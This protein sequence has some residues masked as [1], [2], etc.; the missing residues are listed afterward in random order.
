[1]EGSDYF[2]VI[3]SVLAKKIDCFY[4]KSTGDACDSDYVHRVLVNKRTDYEILYT[5]TIGL[6]N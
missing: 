3:P 1:M 6:V 4:T 5:K 2:E